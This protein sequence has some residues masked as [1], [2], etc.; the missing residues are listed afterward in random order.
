MVGYLSQRVM[1]MYLGRVVEEGEVRQVLEK[2]RHPYTQALWAAGERGETTLEGEPPSPV[3]V[4]KGCS[5]NP[6]C[7]HA[8]KRCR[9]EVQELVETAGGWKTACWKWDKI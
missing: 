4:P 8:E 2:P 7:P 5:F 6:R 9:E 3:N 1:V